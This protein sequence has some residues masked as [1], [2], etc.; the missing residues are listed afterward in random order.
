MADV[1]ACNGGLWSPDAGLAARGGI[2]VL[3]LLGEKAKLVEMALWLVTADRGD[4]SAA[5]GADAA[6]CRGDWGRVAAVP[7]G[8]S[9]KT[10]KAEVA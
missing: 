7:P 4:R 3:K 6:A 1:F 9:D 8:A 5:A 10:K 2:G